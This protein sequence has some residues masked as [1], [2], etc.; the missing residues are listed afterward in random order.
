M[1]NMDESGFLL[2]ETLAVQTEHLKGNESQFL[3]VHKALNN[4]A[5]QV[6]GTVFYGGNVTFPKSGDTVP[7][8]HWGADSGSITLPLNANLKKSTIVFAVYNNLEQLLG[9]KIDQAL[10]EIEHEIGDI[11]EEN[12]NSTSRPPLTFEDFTVGLLYF[13]SI[14][15]FV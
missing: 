15:V 5:F 13:V 8:D 6:A 4:T 7:D 2:A 1:D 12:V 14:R 11:I 9:T 10:S 3:S